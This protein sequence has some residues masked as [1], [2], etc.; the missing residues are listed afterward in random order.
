MVADKISPAS[1]GNADGEV[2][3]KVSGGT[4]PYSYLNDEQSTTTT[5][6]TVDKLSP[7]THTFVVTDAAGCSAQTSVS[8]NEEILFVMKV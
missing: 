2:V 7:G 4:T 3:L 5:L 1:T 6:I 8:V